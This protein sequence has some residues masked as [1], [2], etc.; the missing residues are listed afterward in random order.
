M[1]LLLGLPIAGLVG[2]ALVVGLDDATIADVVQ[3]LALS[4]TST[5]V[6]LAV[7]ILLGTPLAYGLARGWLRGARFIE[8]IIDLPIVLPPRSPA[9]RCCCC[10]AGG[11]PSG[12]SSSRPAWSF[13]SPPRRW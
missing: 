10:S 5:A 6:A 12:Q 8:P 4:L 1:L 9:W 13:R 7:T 2:R 3:A 11:G